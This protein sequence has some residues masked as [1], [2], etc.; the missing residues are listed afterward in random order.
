MVAKTIITEMENAF[1]S[2]IATTRIALAHK[3]DCAT[4]ACLF[5]SKLTLP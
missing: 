1:S 2:A 4:L 3:I 5:I